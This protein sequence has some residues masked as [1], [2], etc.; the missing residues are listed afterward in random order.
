MDHR[1]FVFGRE[2]HTPQAAAEAMAFALMRAIEIL[3]RDHDLE[4]DGVIVP[5][6]VTC[7]AAVSA[8]ADLGILVNRDGSFTDLFRATYTVGGVPIFFAGADGGI[9]PFA[10]TRRPHKGT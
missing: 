1:S 5:A 7:I 10:I 4:P 6:T 9:E 8:A 2:V 3:H